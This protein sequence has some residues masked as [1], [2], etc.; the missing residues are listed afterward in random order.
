MT[1]KKKPEDLLKVGRP[2][3]Y[4]PEFCQL[5]IDMLTKG[6]SLYAVAS[7][8]DVSIDT[9]FEW[10]SAHPEFSE[11]IKIGQAKSAYWWEKRA[12]EFAETGIGNATTIKFG[13]INRA[14]KQ[15][16]DK[17][18]QEINLINSVPDFGD[19]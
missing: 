5:A 11:S 6:F 3:K 16:A 1:K 15:W 19:L 17:T 18:E 7:E 8:C 12:Q 9:I 10:R 2:T 4:Q 13:L 14:K